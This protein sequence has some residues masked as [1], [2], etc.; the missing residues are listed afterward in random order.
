M[1]FCKVIRNISKQV[2]QQTN[3]IKSGTAEKDRETKRETF[4]RMTTT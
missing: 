2:K 3:Q 1:L 4:N